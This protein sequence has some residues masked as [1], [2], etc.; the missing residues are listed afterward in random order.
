MVIVAMMAQRPMRNYPINIAV[1][2]SG[3]LYIAD[4]ENHSIR[5]VGTN[6]VISTVAGIGTFGYHGDGGA[7]TS[8]ALTY[9]TSVAIDS[10]G[11]LYIADQYNHRIRKV[12][13]SGIISTV[14]G[15]GTF[16]DYYSSA[17][18]FQINKFTL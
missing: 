6:G 8:A 7:A 15:T 3:N 12:D 13:T 17:I 11:N 2:S 18:V 1:D 14:A 10:S 9:P 4:T 16:G 5:K